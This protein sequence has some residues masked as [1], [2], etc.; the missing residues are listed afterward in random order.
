MNSFISQVYSAIGTEVSGYYYGV[1]FL[2]AITSTRAKYGTDI[3]VT[4]QDGDNIYIIDGTWLFEGKGGA[5]ENLHVY[6]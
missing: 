1:P 5:Y 4:V 6:L 2:G 3:S